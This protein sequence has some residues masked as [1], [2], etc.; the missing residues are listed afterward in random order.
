MIVIL[1]NNNCSL[2]ETKSVPLILAILINI[3]THFNLP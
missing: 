1:K 2:T 3:I